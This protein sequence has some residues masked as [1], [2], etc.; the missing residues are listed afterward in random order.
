MDDTRTEYRAG[1]VFALAAFLSWGFVPIYFKQLTQVPAVEVLAHRIVWSVLFLG[2]YIAVRGSFAATRETLRNR[3]L[4]RGLVLSGALVAFNW[5]IFVWAVA[6]DRILE[7]SL[8]YFITPIVN[9]VL[10]MVFLGERLRPLQW[11]AVGLAALGTVYLTMDYGELPWVALVLAFSFGFYGLM[12]KQL[13][14]KPV[15]GLFVETLLMLPAAL[16]YLLWLATVGRGSFLHGSTSTDALLVGTGLVTAL[17]LLWF[18]NA[19]RRMPLSTLG[20]FQYL[21]PS[22]S[23]LLAVFVYGEPFTPAHAVAFVSIWLGLALFSTDAI[24]WQ[25]RAV[26]AATPHG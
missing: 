7:T 9:V 4:V 3:R 16:G 20:F 25:R 8:G 17:P 19:A 22:M 13:P 23:F 12:R 11:T 6:H 26:G 5:L 15:Q 1:V 24:L 14:V 10:G 21:A 18:I 2:L